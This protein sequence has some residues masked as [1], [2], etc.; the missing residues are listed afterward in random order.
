M[1]A[2]RTFSTWPLLLI[3]MALPFSARAAVSQ[4]DL[5]DEEYAVYS[6]LINEKYLK[7]ADKLIV[8]LDETEGNTIG[9]NEPDRDEIIRRLPSL[10][11]FTIDDYEAK[12]K[13]P[14]G[15]RNLLRLNAEYVLL[16]ERDRF[17]LFIGQF[18]EGWERF[19]HK[20]PE[21][22]SLVK[23]SKVGFNPEKNQALVYIDH[24]CGAK[25]GAG[26]YALLKK[27]GG[28]WTGEG[29]AQIWVS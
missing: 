15:L 23:L 5:S 24:S 17:Q 6:A 4:R 1:N 7:E 8:I 10:L 13:E 12:N 3:C 19:K 18:A 20:Y 22:V 9:G 29:V 26:A 25:C 14:Q 2:S 27:E 28:V 16:S 11:P 21:A